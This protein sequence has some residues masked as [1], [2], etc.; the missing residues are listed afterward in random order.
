MGAGIAKG[1]KKEFPQ[2]YRADCTTKAGDRSKLGDITYVTFGIDTG[3]RFLTVVNGYT[4]YSYIGESPVDY[5]AIKAV[6]KKIKNLFSGKRIGYPKIGAG[7]GGGDWNTIKKIIG[8]ELKNENHTLVIYEYK[9]PY[10]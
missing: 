4:Q 6:F 3:K 9:N 7:L 5:V 10:K 2:A 1:I 8:E